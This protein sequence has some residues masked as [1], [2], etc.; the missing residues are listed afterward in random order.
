M[1]VGLPIAA[2]LRLLC[3]NLVHHLDETDIDGGRSLFRRDHGA[4]RLPEICHSTGAP[5]QSSLLMVLT[6]TTIGVLF[7]L[8]NAIV[9]DIIVEW[10]TIVA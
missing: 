10:D 5:R 3:L 4:S 2:A 1:A 7:M 6:R 8:S 9:S